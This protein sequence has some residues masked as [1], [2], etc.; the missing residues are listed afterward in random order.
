MDTLLIASKESMK[1]GDI[2]IWANGL[3][4]IDMFAPTRLDDNRHVVIDRLLGVQVIP[5]G[6]EFAM[7]LVLVQVL[8]KIK[9]NWP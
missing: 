3:I 6:A 2:A 9:R 1:A 8:E 5:T 7:A 4:G